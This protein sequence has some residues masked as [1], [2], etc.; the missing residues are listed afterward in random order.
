MCVGR[1]ME[2]VW[3]LSYFIT[4]LGIN[5][6]NFQCLINSPTEPAHSDLRVL[7]NHM[8]SPWSAKFIKKTSGVFIKRV[9]EGLTQPF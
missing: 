6:I 9:P 3:C 4:T 1:E 2:W 7:F 5:D 8:P